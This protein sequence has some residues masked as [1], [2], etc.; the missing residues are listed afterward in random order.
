MKSLRITSLIRFAVVLGSLTIMAVGNAQ[1][2][3]HDVYPDGS[4]LLQSTNILSF[5]AT[6]GAANIDSTGITVQLTSTNLQGNVQVA[7]LSSANGL[8]IGGTVAE[9][10]VTAPLKTNILNYMAVIVVTDANNASTTNTIKFD[11]LSPDLIFEAED[12]DHDSGQFTNNPAPG[13]YAGLDATEGVDTHKGNPL[14][15]PNG[16]RNSGLATETAFDLS[17]TSFIN[18]GWSDYDVGYNDGGNWA[19]YTRTYPAGIYNV[20]MRGSDGGGNAGTA[21]LSVVT[22]GVGTSNQTTTTLGTFTIPVTGD[23]QKYTWAPLK[24]AGGNLVQVTGGAVKTLRVTTGGNYNANFYAAFLVDTN[25]PTVHNIQ[26]DG[27]RL[28]QGASALTFVASSGYTINQSGISVQLTSTNLIGQVV[29]T[30]LTS[31]NGLVVTGTPTDRSVS[32]PLATNIMSYR[33]LIQVTDA[34]DNLAVATANFNTLNPSFTFE[35]EDFDYGSGQFIDN[36]QT[37]AYAGR[38]GNE[39]IDAHHNN[40]AGGSQYYRTNG[41]NNED[42]HDKLRAAYDGTGFSD[43][44][45]GFNDGGNWAN[46]TR[47]YP[48]GTYIVFMRGASGTGNG[49]SATMARVTS[50]VGTS[51]QTTVNLGTFVIPATGDWQKYTWVPLKDIVGNFVQFTGGS[52]KT[53]RVT[54]GGGFNPNFYAFFPADTSPPVITSIYPN[55]VNQFQYTNALSFVTSSPSGIGTNQITVTLD[56]VV[57]SGLIF[58]GSSTSW[59]VRYPN[60][61]VNAVHTAVITVMA[62]N[63]LSQSVT[64]SFDT[65]KATYYTWEAED[66]DFG[67]GQSVDNPQ[68]NAYATLGVMTNVDFHSVDDGGSYDYRPGGTATSLTA[69]TARTQ[70]TGHSDYNIGFFGYGE[71]GNYTRHYPVGTYNVWLRAAT[72]N[73]SSSAFLEKVTSG[74]GT[75]NQTTSLLGKF[76]VPSNGWDTYTWA[77][78]NDANGQPASITFDGSAQTLRLDTPSGTGEQEI[79]VNY[80]MISPSTA[81]TASLN[82]GNISI[83]VQTQTGFTYQMQRKNTLAAVTWTSVGIPFTG[84]D[85]IHVVTDPTAGS[86]G[87]YRVQITPLP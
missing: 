70:F 55:G 34:N 43:Y 18:A 60:L 32:A 25:F 67:G 69:D 76:S 56:G 68:F 50:G 73:G 30:N 26:P 64:L 40:F 71:W 79:N 17:R 48:A 5:G 29:V 20:Y 87:F 72:G 12:F 37:N 51:N 27:S 33:A 24:D 46:Y 78:L 61:P 19:N 59:S 83:S 54:A 42:C 45:L 22:S 14:N 85:T 36:P 38:G 8:V 84:N 13:T 66:Y 9:R 35:S 58:S 4:R 74:F 23:W 16:Y 57:V 49:G 44:D 53:L 31:A 6:A 77:R 28:F 65:F 21:T 63:G 3:I 11:T 62:N 2:V 7:N 81:L 52:V 47:T 80:I 75:T 10:T 15:G 86:S 1:P 41:Y 39:G 82:G